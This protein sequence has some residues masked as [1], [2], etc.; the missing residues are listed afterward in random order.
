V[1]PPNIAVPLLLA[2]HALAAAQPLPEF[3]P[4]PE[5]RW[6]GPVTNKTIPDV[7]KDGE[8]KQEMSLVHCNGKATIQFRREDGS[9]EPAFQVSA[10]PFQRMF[11]LVYLNAEKPDLGGWVESQ[12]WTLV[13][14]RPK[15][16]TLA[17]SRAV[18]NQDKKPEDP[19]FTFR[20]F[21]WGTV[22]HDP[23]WCDRA[24]TR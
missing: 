10:V 23:Q 24:A 4:L 15:G 17:Q 19:W 8:W 20:R 13:D 1:Q 14:A 9:L 11:I 2:A 21:A 3:P 5:G 12:V 7:D 6:S 22:E 18:M 16:W